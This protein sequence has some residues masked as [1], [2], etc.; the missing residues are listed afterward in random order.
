[1]RTCSMMEFPLSEYTARVDKLVAQ[2]KAASCDAVLLTVEEN[3]R[4]FFGYRSCAWSSQYECPAM[5]VV[6]REGR[7]A[8][9]TSER[10]RG[11]AESTSCLDP[12]EILVYSGFGHQAFPE[13][14]VPALTD[15]LQRLGA[16]KGRLG[17]ETGAASRMRITYRDYRGL[18]SALP[19]LAA[20]D[21]SEYILQ[22]RQIKSPLELAVIRECCGIAVEAFRLAMDKVKVGETTEEDMCRD[23]MTACFDLGADDI[24]YLL[25]VEFGPHRRQPNCMPGT[26]VY[27]RDDWCVFFD[28]GPSLKGY[29]TDIIR[30][31]MLA[32]PTPAQQAFYDISLACHRYCMEKVR[33]GVTIGE[34]VTAHDAFMRSRGV[35]DICQTMSGGGH[36]VGLDVHE[37]PIIKDTFADTEFRA[38]MVFAFE[39]TII[40]PEEGQLVLENNYLV[41]EDGCECLSPALQDIYVPGRQ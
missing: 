35:A 27:E 34:I 37:F 33:P 22:I 1:M 31:G 2:L 7:I 26:Q 18:F 6:T 24:E 16:A 9:I 5:A 15:A 32:K 8:L 4:Y 10:R 11:T 40:H 29:I 13:T 36:G 38:G 20:V 19:E 3:L 21:F 39:P 12:E 30:I 23:Y 17:T 28:T 14:I 25:I 41:T